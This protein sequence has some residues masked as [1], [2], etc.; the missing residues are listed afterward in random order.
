MRGAS[1]RLQIPL[2]NESSFNTCDNSY[3]ESE[4]FKTCEDYGV[5][6]DPMRYR[7]KNFIGLISTVFVGLMII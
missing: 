3:T 6:N 1:K 2:P 4:F 7:M 5:P